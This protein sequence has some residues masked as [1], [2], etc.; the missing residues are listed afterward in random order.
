[1]ITPTLIEGDTA[2]K[3]QIKSS[4]ALTTVFSLTALSERFSSVDAIFEY[5]LQNQNWLNNAVIDSGT[6][7]SNSALLRI[8]C[9]AD[10]VQTFI[11][12]NQSANGLTLGV[13]CEV[14]LRTIPSQEVFTWSV[15]T[16]AETISPLGSQIYNVFDNKVLGVDLGGNLMSVNNAN[17]FEVFNNSGIVFTLSAPLNPRWAQQIRNG[18]YLVLFA[19]SI[20]EF[21]EN[22]A[23]TSRSPIDL[24]AIDTDLTHFCYSPLTQ[25]ILLSGRAN[26]AVTEIKWGNGTVVKSLSVDRPSGVCYN[27]DDQSIWFVASEANNWVIRADI[28]TNTIATITSADGINPLVAP[29]FVESQTG[30]RIN[31]IEAKGAPRSYGTTAGTHPALVRAANGP[32]ALRNLLFTPILRAQD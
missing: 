6:A 28:P 19:N 23:T 20:V 4:N 25:T 27:A 16:L 9:S 13:P 7:G 29:R 31:I 11:R 21:N 32:D 24:S 18:I 1:M 3:L 14:R 2:L 5:R 30:G 12:W 26:N 15:S 8:P 10:G 17:Q 22:G